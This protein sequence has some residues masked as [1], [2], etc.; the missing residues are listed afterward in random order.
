[1]FSAEG[2]KTKCGTAAGG[3]RISARS[4]LLYRLHQLC[5]VSCFKIEFTLSTSTS[6]TS[7]PPPFHIMSSRNENVST[8]LDQRLFC[9]LAL[10]LR[11]AGLA[12]GV[13]RV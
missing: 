5:P 2:C 6:L 9:G 7:S 4:P 8:P 1:M 10:R 13:D 3:V 12:A 11:S